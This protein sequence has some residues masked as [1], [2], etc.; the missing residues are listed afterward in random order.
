MK[1]YDL[2]LPKSFSSKYPLS[3]LCRKLFLT[4]TQKNFNPG[5]GFSVC[6]SYARDHIR[7]IK[8]SSNVRNSGKIPF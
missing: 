6:K 5:T 8:V 3:H 7:D 1:N 4:G 2:S